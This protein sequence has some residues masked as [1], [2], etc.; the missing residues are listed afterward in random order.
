MDKLF[1]GGKFDQN[2]LEQVLISKGN[3]DKVVWTQN[4]VR[5]KMPVLAVLSPE[6]KE[7]IKEISPSSYEDLLSNIKFNY[8]EETL[9]YAGVLSKIKSPAKIKL[10]LTKY[11][12]LIDCWASTDVIKVKLSQQDMFDTAKKYTRSS[13]T[14]IRR[15]G[16]RLF[17]ELIN[18]NFIDQIFDLISNA[19]NEREYYV[20]MII[21]WLLCECFVKNREKTLKFIKDT[22]LNDFVFSKFVSKCRDSYR[23]SNEDKNLL[24]SML[25]QSL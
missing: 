24:C 9:I 5:T 23:V 25:K 2:I 18:T 16:Y 22:K 17:F 14:F 15:A 10:Y 20:N 3:P 21:A 7:I 11:V 13:Q 6:I 12:K 1:E 19:Y 8:Y 4:I